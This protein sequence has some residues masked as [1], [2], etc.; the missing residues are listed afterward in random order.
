MKF[1]GW[2][3]IAL[4]LVASSAAQTAPKSRSMDQMHGGCDNYAA[5]LTTEMRLM[6]MNAVQINAASQAAE[7]PQVRTSQVFSINLLPQSQVHFALAPAQDR[8]GPERWAGLVALGTL[9]KGNWRVSADKS[10][11]IDLIG[12]GQLLPSPA[13]EMQ[14]ECPTIFKTVVFEAPGTVTV[15]LQ[16]SGATTQSVRLLITSAEPNK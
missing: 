13:F 9:P 5:N 14:T 16:I 8:G 4:F 11:W 2:F 6:S 12:S 3:G 1:A 7:A 15:L 10:V